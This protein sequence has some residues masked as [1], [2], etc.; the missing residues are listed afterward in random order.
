MTMDENIQAKQMETADVFGKC[1]GVLQMK[2]IV[3]GRQLD[4]LTVSLMAFGSLPTIA[5]FKMTLSAAS[6]PDLTMNVLPLG[7]PGEIVFPVA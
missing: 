7:A 2:G 6:A 4:E 3:A 1:M 5:S